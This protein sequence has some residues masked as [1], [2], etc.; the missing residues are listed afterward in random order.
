MVTLPDFNW[1]R[2]VIIVDTE[3]NWHRTQTRSQPAQKMELIISAGYLSGPV[4]KIDF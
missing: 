3:N 4:P 2:L 1:C